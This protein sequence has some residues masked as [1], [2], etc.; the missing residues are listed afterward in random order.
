MK[1]A[2]FIFEMLKG[3][4]YSEEF[5]ETFKVQNKAFIRQRILTFPVIFF[6]FL[7]FLREAYLKSS[8]ISVKNSI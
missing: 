2:A 6:L 7:V 4:V 8:L 3:K 1:T 5:R